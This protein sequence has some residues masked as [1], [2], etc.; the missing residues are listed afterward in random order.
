M[1]EGMHQADRAPMNLERPLHYRIGEIDKKVSV[2]PGLKGLK[3]IN[4]GKDGGAEREF[5]FLEVMGT[6]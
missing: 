3:I 4:V 1:Q 2:H 6:N 5:H